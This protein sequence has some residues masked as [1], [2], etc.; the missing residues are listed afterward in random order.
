MASF[1]RI[2]LVF[3]LVTLLYTPSFECR[4]I[5]NI[6][7]LATL[8]NAAIDGVGHKSV[9]RVL[10]SVP[11]PGEGH[12]SIDGSFESVPSP[13]IGHES[14]GVSFESVPSPGVGN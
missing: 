4:K 14:I 7:T 9:E 1:S 2:A 3:L 10:E 11:S 12:D 8:H 13:G 5:L 6:R